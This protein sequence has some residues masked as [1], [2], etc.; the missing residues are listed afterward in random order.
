MDGH[1]LKEV[2]PMEY[3]R[4]P[5]LDKQVTRVALGTW[6]IGGWMW[7]GT[8]ETQSIKTIHTALDKGVNI[9]DT[10]PVYGFG[11]SEEIVGKALKA[12]GR[13]EEIVIA[14]KVALAWNPEKNAVWRDSSP[15]RIR[16]EVEDSLKRL[17]TDVID[18]YQIHWPDPA[19]PFEKTAETLAELK[20]EGKIRVAGVSNYSPDQ[21]DAFRKGADLGVCQPPYNIFESAIEQDI[22]P[23][24]TAE[25]IA[26]LT[27]GALCRGLLSGKMSPKREFP[28]DDLRNIDP[29]F[30]QP[31][32]DQY[33]TAV[34]KLQ[35][36]VREN[37]ERDIIHLAVRFVL[38]KGAS[39]AL[40]GGRRPDDLDPLA[41]MFGWQLTANDFKK[42]D[43]ILGETIKN[44]VGPGFMAP[45]AK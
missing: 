42:I 29:K 1:E 40:W 11:R 34:K 10:A 7:G 21:M 24:C 41:D 31:R 6:A 32:F 36:F 3:I 19:V 17:Q 37:Y 20:K 22:L 18:I 5:G 39:V 38:D 16:Q 27:Y 13:R 14:T 45:P 30:K 12:Y 26:T 15:E 43:E 4:I 33:L 8:D 35:G 2:N 23:Y 9:I 25:G 28:G 44:P